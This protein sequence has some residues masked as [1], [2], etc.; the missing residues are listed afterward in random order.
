MKLRI[1]KI[2]GC[3]ALAGSMT[4]SIAASAQQRSSLVSPRPTAYDT[5]R[6]TLVQ[7]T[8]LSYTEDSPLLPIGAHV[9]VQTSTGTVDVHL[10]SA[11]YLR[12]NHFSLAP[13]D[14]VSF[15]GASIPA[16]KGTVF[17]ARIAQKGS[18]SIAIRSARG[19]LLATAATRTLSQAQRAQAAQQV[20]P[21]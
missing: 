2:I 13:G 8:V 18:Q 17:M 1:R 6:E 7:G 14:S 20:S 9:A 19:F 4:L 16:N 5:T 15:V 11:S 3:A 12:A 10:G 21:R